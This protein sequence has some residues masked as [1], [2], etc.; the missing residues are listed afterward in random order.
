MHK[1][2]QHAIREKSE[3]LKDIFKIVAKI[4]INLYSLEKIGA[5]NIFL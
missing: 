1:F 2:L 3:K 5:N 4:I